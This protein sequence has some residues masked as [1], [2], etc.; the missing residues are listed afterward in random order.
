M[1]EADAHAR[2]ASAISRFPE[3]LWKP[4]NYDNYVTSKGDFA[5]R[6]PPTRPNQY[7]LEVRSGP[8]TRSP[9]NAVHSP[10][11]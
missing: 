8:C 4:V 7:S 5:M 9:L 11:K 6:P 2:V 10:R 1:A 3:S